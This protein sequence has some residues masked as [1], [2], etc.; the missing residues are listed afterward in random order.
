MVGKAAILGQNAL[1]TMPPKLPPGP[2]PPPVPD[3]PEQQPS[4][5]FLARRLAIVAAAIAAT[6]GIGLYVAAYAAAGSGIPRGTEV[7]GIDIGGMSESE[8]EAELT[9]ALP[10][11]LGRTVTV[12]AGPKTITLDA[13]ASGLAIDARG[14]V[15]QTR[16][17]SL[18]PGRLVPA[19]FGAKDEVQPVLSVDEA[20]LTKAVAK[21]SAKV[22]QKVREGRVAFKA[23]KTV[24]TKPR[25]GRKVLTAE[26]EQALR[27]AY[28]SGATTVTAQVELTQPVIGAAEVDRVLTQFARPA[29]SGP[30]SVS[31]G[32][33]AVVLSPTELD[34]YLKIRVV[35]TALE[36]TVD[37]DRMVADLVEDNENLINLPKD[38]S[39]TFVQNKPVLVAGADGEKVD[40]LTFGE[41]MRAALV[42]P[43][44]RSI[45]ADVVPAGPDLT[46]EE[47]Q[48]LGITEKISTYRSEYPIA[49]YR[50]TN[51][52]R[53]AELINESLV[54]PGEIF[55]LNDTIGE[56][57]KAN[58]FVKGFV[59]DKGDFKEDLG[60]GVSQS[61]TTVFNAV[62][63]AG[64][65]DVEHHTHSLYI[66]RY[67]AGREA[68]VA[69]GS[70]DLRFRNNFPTGVLIR[71]QHERG[72]IRV[73]FWGTKQFD[74]IESVS[75]SRTNYKQPDSR[76]SASSNCLP[77]APVS[78]FDIVVT[79][80]FYKDGKVVKREKFFTRYIPTDRITCV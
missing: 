76:T 5:N 78:G 4:P 73:T 31:L 13:I 79:R 47:A 28:E 7:L 69:F 14:T 64:L 40:P 58:G 60:G 57:T 80:V 62:F 49:P 66:G 18:N 41:R 25:E 24:V 2:P 56:R 51:I 19:L 38:A 55:S 35:G 6:L 39:F 29:M 12:T 37:T 15:E 23:G 45:V 59:I 26:T 17:R 16:E 48:N 65:E 68:T 42:A 72:H 44:P 32:G 20:A 8:A 74:R 1:V 75:S 70:K 22:D 46:T 63:F 3:L 11:V 43:A 30:V 50:V 36:W 53:A 71:A 21:I 77:Q 52:G 10:A 61:A 33:Q 27:E 9:E 67:P 54:L 34:D